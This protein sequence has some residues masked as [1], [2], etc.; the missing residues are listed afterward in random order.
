M[1]FMTRYYHSYTLH[2]RLYA[3]S[4]Y[5]QIIHCLSFLVLMAFLFSSCEKGPTKIGS[6]LLPGSDFVTIHSTDTLSV[7]SYTNY[8]TSVPTSNP[9]NSFIGSIYDPY[10]GTTTAEFVSQ[11]RLS[12]AWRIG[13]VTID[14][15]RLFLQ[16]DIVKG[17][18]PDA[19][20]LLRISEIAD[21]IN[22]DS[23]YYSNTQTDTTDFH[24]DVQLPALTPD[25]VNHISVS[26]PIEFG[27][28]IIRDTSKLFYNNT[29]PDF[30]SFFKGL[31]FRIYPSSDPLLVSFSTVSSVTRGGMYNNYFALYMHDTAYVKWAY[32]LI[33]DAVHKNACYN[34]F[35]HDFSTSQPEKMIAHINDDNYRDSLSYS[36]Y[37]NGVFTRIIFP[38]LEKLKDDFTA[39]KFSINKARLLVP[40]YFDGD[41]YT[42]STVSPSLRLRYENKSGV[43]NDVPDYFTDDSH[44]FFDGNLNKADS[45]YSFNIAAYI[46]SYFE[47]KTGDFK[48]E[49]EI[50]QGIT[51]IN[52]VIL[53][54]NKNKTPIKF[55]M[56]YTRF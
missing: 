28:Y 31:Y 25:T 16:L 37:L 14:S 3:F 18:S 34:K 1:T 13:P 24:V 2:G 30:R 11:V 53:R 15:V 32:Y 50:Y 5:Q 4:Y 20:H 49:L 26:L 45:V 52:S 23:V 48:P 56:T 27:E 40:V 35:S 39:G 55:E 17:G 19:D 6:E 38:G 44:I 36:Q 21:Q 41:I 54:A 9:P 42:A 51:G 46:Q 43:K 10:F 33:L 8:N 47:D 22:T 12:S 29:K 7:F